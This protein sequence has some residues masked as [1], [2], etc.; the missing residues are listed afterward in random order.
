MSEP[1]D[2][3]RPRILTHKPA[4]A[5]PEPQGR[6]LL[7]ASLIVTGW[8]LFACGLVGGALGALAGAAVLVYRLITTGAP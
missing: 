1:L 4:D 8:A 6:T 2:Y 5:P 7:A 3:L